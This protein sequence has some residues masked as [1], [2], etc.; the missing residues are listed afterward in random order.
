MQIISDRPRSTCGQ[1]SS[2]KSHSAVMP[3][4]IQDDTPKPIK[5][6]INI[7]RRSIFDDRTP[8]SGAETNMA[9]PETKTVSPVIRLS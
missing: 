4:S 6:I 2:W 8:A 9:S 3:V 1:S 5:P 7:S